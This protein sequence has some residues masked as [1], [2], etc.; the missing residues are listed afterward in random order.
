MEFIKINSEQAKEFA[1]AIF[2]EIEIYVN[3]HADEFE[4]FLK[5]EK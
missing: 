5:N 2:S 4:E 1:W 3:E